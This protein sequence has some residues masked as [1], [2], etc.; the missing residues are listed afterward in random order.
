MYF[1][2]EKT[3]KLLALIMSLM[4]IYI[5]NTKHIL[6]HLYGKLFNKV[7]ETGNIPE[8]WLTGKIV[9][10]YKKVEEVNDVNNYRG[11]TL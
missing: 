10:I 1:K 2:T 5:K 11:I 6:S 4:N 9:P 7:L 8:N 3:I